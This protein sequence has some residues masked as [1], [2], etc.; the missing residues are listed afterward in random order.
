M[1]KIIIP[2]SILI[3]V[4]IFAIAGYLDYQNKLNNQK[5]VACTMDAKACP[6]GSYV[7]RIAPNC[8]FALCPE[9]TTILYKNDE[10]GFEI[11]LPQTWKEYSIE[12]QTWEGQAIS[13]NKKIYSGVKII[14]KNPQTTVEQKWQDIPI[15][16][17]TPDVWKLI[18]EEKVSVSAA[19]TPPEKIGENLKY[20]FATPPRWYGFTDEQ[21][22]PEALDIV[23]T[24]KAF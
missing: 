5:P 17:F 24:F 8:E 19:P 14:V 3:V 13:G 20:I 9:V 2:L 11:T 16:V 7:G 10:Y 12:H 21:G 22:W 4:I 1:K 23:K 6:D 15:M 18:A